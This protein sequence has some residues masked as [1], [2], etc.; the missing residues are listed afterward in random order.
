[1]T[2]SK[3]DGLRVSF[4]SHPRR[5]PACHPKARRPFKPK[6]AGSTPVGRIPSTTPHLP[7]S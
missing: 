4:L 7:V 5:K 3:A 2:R 1:M 6:V